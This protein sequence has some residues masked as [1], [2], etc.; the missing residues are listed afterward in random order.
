[1]ADTGALQIAII[2]TISNCFDNKKPCSNVGM[3]CPKSKSE[4][5]DKSKIELRTGISNTCKHASCLNK[6]HW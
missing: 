5:N 2:I 4:L 6:S 3:D 1:M